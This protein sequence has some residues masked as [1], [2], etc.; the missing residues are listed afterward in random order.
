[1][2]ILP[3]AG[4]VVRDAPERRIEI[5]CDDDALNATW[6]RLAPGGDGADLHVHRRH[7]D[8]FYVLEGELTVR[9]GLADEPARVPAGTVARVPPDVI[10]G[11]RNGSTADMRYLNF[12][13]PGMEFAQYM[14]ALRD[15]REFS[16]DQYPPPPGGARPPGDAVI[17]GAEALDGGLLL[18]DVEEIGL[19][20]LRAED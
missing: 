18:A 11:F 9:L 15:G 8:L 3:G 12:H 16:Y 6:A 7:S 17:G 19:A 2:L 13:A 10:H 20:E 4:E 5:L 14:R 1:M